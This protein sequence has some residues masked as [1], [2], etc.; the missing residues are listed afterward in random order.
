LT[1][2]LRSGISFADGEVLNSTDAYFSY[3]RLLV[4]DGSAPIGHGTQASW[5][6]QQ[7]L[8]PSLSTTLCSCTQ[9][10]GNQYVQKVLNENFVQVTG[11]LTLQLNIMTP[12][13]ALPYLIGQSLWPA[14]LAPDYV[15][16]HDLALWTQSSLG[17]SLPYPTLSGNITQQIDQY[18][19]DYS[20]TCNSGATPKG[21]AATYLDSSTSGSLAGSGPYTVQSVNLASNV[22]TLSA[23]SNYWGGPYG[24]IHPHIPTV[25]YKFV[26]DQTTREI[27]LQNAAASD[28]AMVMDVTPTNIYDVARAISP[29]PSR[30]G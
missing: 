13:S 7:L 1:A 18:F 16:Q 25:I 6:L 29:R 3:N 28:Q 10:Y 26:P 21:C 15:M 4:M 20:A 19:M 24:N 8:D 14:I 9:T 11:P 27:Y 5:I 17:Y 2:T 12:N 23:Y 30:A 22:I